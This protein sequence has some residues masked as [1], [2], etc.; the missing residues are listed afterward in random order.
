MSS[1]IFIKMSFDGYTQMLVHRYISMYA[2]RY[3]DV[4]ADS[5]TKI[6]AVIYSTTDRPQT[7]NVYK[8]MQTG[9]IILNKKQKI[10]Y[11]LQTVIG[12]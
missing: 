3:T 6:S 11:S 12:F 10:I 7:E 8:Y 1:D 2:E 9:T 4:S 5:W